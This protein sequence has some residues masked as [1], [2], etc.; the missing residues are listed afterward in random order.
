MADAINGR[1]WVSV[2]VDVNAPAVLVDPCMPRT[3]LVFVSTWFE[4]HRAHQTI[5][6]RDKMN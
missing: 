2:V 1:D 5:R 6:K 4:S 3:L